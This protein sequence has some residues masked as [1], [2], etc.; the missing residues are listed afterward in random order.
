MKKPNKFLNKKSISSLVIAAFLIL[1]VLTAYNIRFGNNGPDTA[2]MEETE[3]EETIGNNDDVISSGDARIED[4]QDENQEEET[5]EE[6]HEEETTENAGAE[7]EENQSGD[8]R[9]DGAQEEESRGSNDTSEE[10]EQEAD[11]SHFSYDG[12]RKMPWPVMGNVI[13]PYSMDTTVYYTTLDQYA[14]NDGV[15]I[16]AKKGQEVTATADGRI[17]NISESDRYGTT[18]TMVIGEY[19]EVSYSQV[20]NVKFEI[21]DEVEEG[22]VIATVAEPTRSFTLEGPHLFFK[23][24]YKGEPVNPTDYLEA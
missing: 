7:D 3:V 6:S 21:G 23:M 11:F 12:S 10:E 15:L 8:G 19:Y 20:E 24:T 1:S 2:E 13:L 16:G 17:V 18:V 22:E 5:D 4:E 9:D 14:C